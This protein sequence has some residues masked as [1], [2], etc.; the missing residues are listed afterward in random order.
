MRTAEAKR[1]RLPVAA[2][3]KLDRLYAELPAIEC[4]RLCEECCGPVMMS[5]IEWERIIARCGKAPAPTP[6]QRQRLECPML[7]DGGCSVY[8]I[9]PL[10][11]RLWGLV[12]RM[13]CPHGCTP[14]R[15]L[16]DEE[17]GA[18]LTRAEQLSRDGY[19]KLSAALTGDKSWPP[20][21]SEKPSTGT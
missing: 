4:K 6:E 18:F 10:I 11:C 17:A 12:E 8:D 13:A 19:R 1:I 2:M 16:T 3:G 5:R 20:S 7:K 14:E 9:R 15:W 21:N